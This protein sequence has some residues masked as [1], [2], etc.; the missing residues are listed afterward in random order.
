MKRITCLA[1][2]ATMVGAAACGDSTS[3]E[4]VTGTYTLATMNGEPVPVLLVF[5]NSYSY[6]VH[7]GQITLDAGGAVTV[8]T[9]ERERSGGLPGWPTY[10]VDST[11]VTVTGSYRRYKRSQTHYL[12]TYSDGSSEGATI[13]GSELTR[14]APASRY[15]ETPVPWVYRR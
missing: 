2:T 12:L 10:R 14:Y 1:V 7:S 9:R 6:S 13:R 4:S 8:V 15:H 11:T 5:T 3:P